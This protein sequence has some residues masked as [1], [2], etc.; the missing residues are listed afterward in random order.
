MPKLKGGGESPPHIR[1]EGR[2]LRKECLL[3]RR[4]A[5]AGENSGA[6]VSPA[7]A[8]HYVSTPS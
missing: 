4:V 8:K 5:A 3:R 2:F 1:G 7:A 6:G